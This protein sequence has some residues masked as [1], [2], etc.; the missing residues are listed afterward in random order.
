MKPTPRFAFRPTSGFCLA[1]IAACTTGA[2]AV[3]IFSSDFTSD[4]SPN[5][6]LSSGAALNTNGPGG[7]RAIELVDTSGTLASTAVLTPTVANGAPAFNTALPGQELLR[8]TA[9]FAVTTLTAS[10]SNVNVPRIILGDLADPANLIHVGL[11][12]TSGGN[13]IL[14][15]GKGDSSNPSDGATRVLLHNYGSYNGGD[16]AANDTNDVYVTLTLT[17]SS[18]T[19]AMTITATN[20]GVNGSGSL[21]GFSGFNNDNLTLS[22]VSGTSAQTT[23]YL[24]NVTL[25]T[26]PI[27]EPAA[28]LLGSVATLGLLLRRR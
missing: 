22:F 18:V 27:P 26:L 14:Y 25:E 6:V 2:G 11:G 17:Y 21:T 28:A 4:P 10:G 13:V 1:V 3:T 24:D 7:S 9:D 8:L 23:A 16:V 15:A 20:G 5:F 12:R 19:N